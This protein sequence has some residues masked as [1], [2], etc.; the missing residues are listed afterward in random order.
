MLFI[1]CSNDDDDD[2]KGYF[3]PKNYSL[4]IMLNILTNNREVNITYNNTNLI[5]KI[6][7]TI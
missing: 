2:P 3:F 1:Q 7:F 6:E 4:R 5:S